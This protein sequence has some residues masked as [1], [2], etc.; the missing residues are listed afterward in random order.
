[1]L[2]GI[3]LGIPELAEDVPF[4]SKS[5]NK[6][7]R[8]ERMLRSKLYEYICETLKLSERGFARKLSVSPATVTQWLYTDRKP[9]TGVLTRMSSTLNLT[10]KQIEELFAT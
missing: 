6:P 9:R 10:W 7:C 8:G 4:Y 1:M 5:D 3:Q 2:L